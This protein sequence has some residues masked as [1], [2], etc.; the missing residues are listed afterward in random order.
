ML[1]W[2]FFG[3]LTEQRGQPDFFFVAHAQHFW[4]PSWTMRF[5]KAVA[6]L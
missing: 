6:P 5:E 3:A 1:L 4:A 2:L